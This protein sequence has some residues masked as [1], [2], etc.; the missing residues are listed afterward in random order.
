MW[1]EVTFHYLSEAINNIRLYKV[2]SPM[3]LYEDLYFESDIEYINFYEPIGDMITNFPD[4]IIQNISQINIHEIK[5]AKTDYKKLYE[6]GDFSDINVYLDNKVL[7]LHR[8][9]LA[10]VSKNLYKTMK[11]NHNGDIILDDVNPI[12]AEQLFK[13]IYGYPNKLNSIET[14]EI[15]FLAEFFNIEIEWKERIISLQLNDIRHNNKEKYYEAILL[16]NKIYPYK[17]PDELTNV[18][19]NE[20]LNILFK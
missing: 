18:I 7:K 20:D 8:I 5:I 16:I 9:I 10:S 15:I 3:L 19:K 4:S 6:S 13:L 14:L 17:I 12:V 1:Y 2:R 11:D